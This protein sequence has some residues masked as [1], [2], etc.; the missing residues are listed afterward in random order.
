[1][2]PRSHQDQSRHAVRPQGDLHRGAGR[3]PDSVPARRPARDRREADAA[4][5]RRGEGHRPREVH[6]RHE[7]AGD[8]LREARDLAPRARQGRRASTSPRRSSSRA[9]RSPRRRDE[10]GALR[11]QTGRGRRRD[12]AADRRRGGAGS[13]RSTTSRSRTPRATSRRRRKARPQVLANRPNRAADRQRRRP[14]PAQAPKVDAALKAAAHVVE[15]R[16]EDAG[17]DALL[18]RDARDRG[19]L[20]SAGPPQGLGFDPGDF[21]VRARARR[22]VPDSRGE[23]HRDHAVHGRR[24]R[25]QVPARVLRARWPPSSRR[26]RGCR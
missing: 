5:R 17:A 24:I 11:G 9:S 25:E 18:P 22:D 21:G 26:R 12:D 2:S 15:G 8:A 7:P 3:R 6:A 1:M 14:L 23:R 4:P 16:R 19:A 10:G 13:S 20:G